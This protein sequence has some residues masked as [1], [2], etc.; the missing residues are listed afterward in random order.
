[1]STGMRSQLKFVEWETSIMHMFK[2]SQKKR[3][4]AG[5]RFELKNSLKLMKIEERKGCR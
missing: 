3:S 4:K 1:M 2:L 5:K